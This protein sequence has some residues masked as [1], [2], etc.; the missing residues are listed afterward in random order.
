VHR[1]K[2]HAKVLRDVLEGFLHRPGEQNRKLW[3]VKTNEI[4]ARALA[5]YKPRVSLLVASN[6]RVRLVYL[7]TTFAKVV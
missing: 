6:S 1:Q 5:K 4:Y 7:E 3:V 2:I